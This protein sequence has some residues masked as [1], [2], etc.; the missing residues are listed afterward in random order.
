MKNLI[1][2]G[3][4]GYARE[5]YNNFIMTSS[6]YDIKIKGFLD[7]K[8]DALAG[9]EGFPPILSSVEDY[10][11]QENDIFYC[12][13]GDS[14][15]RQKYADI[16]KNRGGVFPPMIHPTAIIHPN[17]KIGEGVSIG[18]FCTISANVT[19]GNFSLI[20]GYS[21][22]GHDASVGDNCSLGTY[23]FLG[24]YVKVE[25]GATLHTRSTILPHKKVGAGAI[26]GAGSVVLR[27]VKPGVSV[28]GN[29][30]KEI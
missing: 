6:D 13:L 25:D 5:F 27:N 29:P 12:A 7:D 28:F 19:I 20:F 24:G 1:I 9:F 22:L 17:V 3:A 26:V 16:I 15:A 30:A 4:R 14:N 21:N 18:Q 23:V 11:V 2:I 10:D 8:S